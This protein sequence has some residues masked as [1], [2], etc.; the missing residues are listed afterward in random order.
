MKHDPCP[1]PIEKFRQDTVKQTLV[2]SADALG[3]MQGRRPGGTLPDGTTNVVTLKNHKS[4]D[5]TYW[6]YQEDEV[7]NG[8][9]VV[10][11]YV[12][13]AASLKQYPQ[14]SGW[15]MRIKV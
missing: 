13:V 4:G 15:R 12:P 5:T 6:K 1:H 7:Q 14:Y 8:F 9:V 2:A 11:V 10:W 3:Y